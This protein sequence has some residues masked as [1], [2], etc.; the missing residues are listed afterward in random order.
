MSC[1]KKPGNFSGTRAFDHDDFELNQSKIIMIIKQALLSR[2]RHGFGVIQII[3]L[4][5]E[6]IERGS[7]GGIE[8]PRMGGL[9]V[10]SRR[11]GRRSWS[12]GLIWRTVSRW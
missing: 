12:S 3:G 4:V 2:C 5:A 8:R 6:R 10:T 9:S 7:L 11:L 1:P